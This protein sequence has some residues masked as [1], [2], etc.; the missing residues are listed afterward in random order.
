MCRSLVHPT[1]VLLVLW[2][3]L[4]MLPAA[5]GADDLGQKLAA[6]VTIHRDE[7]GVPHIEGPTDASVSFGFAYAQAEDYF[8]QVED[9]YVASIGRYAELYGEPG[10]E[11][12]LLNRSFEIV[13]TSKADFPQLEPPIRAICEAYAAGLNHFLASHPEVK[14]RL[15]THFEPWNVIAYER[16]VLLEFLFGKAQRLED[17]RERSHGRD[18][19]GHRLQHLGHRPQPHQVGQGHAVCQ[20]ASALVRLRAVLRRAPAQRRGVGLRRVGFL[21]RA[22]G[23]DRP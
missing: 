5:C 23:D 10:L 7:W 13:G 8:W 14:P 12:D 18:A 19:G 21:R 3:C 16:Y 9:T 2:L 17:R 6:Q 1:G 20:S 15:I 11:K 22:A 4:A